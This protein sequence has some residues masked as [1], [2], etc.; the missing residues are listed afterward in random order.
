MSKKIVEDIFKVIAHCISYSSDHK[1][2]GN[3]E[4]HLK[5]TIED[6]LQYKAYNYKIFSNIRSK[7][8]THE[9]EQFLCRFSQVDSG[10]KSIGR[11]SSM[12]YIYGDYIIKTATKK[13]NIVLQKIIGKFDEYLRS[14]NGDT[15]LNKFYGAFRIKSRDYGKIYF[16]IINNIFPEG[17]TIKKKF[18]LKGSTVNRNVDPKIA[19]D[20][21][22]TLKEK[23]FMDLVE[24]ETLIDFSE[25]KYEMFFDVV[26]RDLEF[27]KSCGVMDY[28]LLIG[29]HCQNN[30]RL[31]IT[32][33]R[34]ILECTIENIDNFDF[35]NVKN[36][37][38][39]SGL[40]DF[41]SGGIRAHKTKEV[42][43]IAIIDFLQDYNGRKVMERAVKNIRY[44]KDTMSC[45]PPAIYSSRMLDFLR[46]KFPKPSALKP[47]TATVVRAGVY[48]VDDQSGEVQ[49]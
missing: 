41:M 27:L 31:R 24:R 39:T 15:L 6:T 13:E 22:V 47:Q 46:K 1:P 19:N 32:D 37:Q 10:L 26:K 3:G 2:K 29:I 14:T 7:Y 30:R 45:V 35:T 21:D 42:Y 36:R 28:S 33:E 20:P 12:F 44:K 40:F 38:S 49:A 16:V 25:R 34:V 18:D 5:K 48:N 43:F 23:E 11:S 17:F 4:I 8:C 9:E